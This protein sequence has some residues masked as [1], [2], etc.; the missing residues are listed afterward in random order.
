MKD[1]FSSESDKYAKFRPLYPEDMFTFIYSKVESKGSVWD[2]GTGSGQVAKKLAEEFEKVFGTDISESQLKNAFQAEN[3]HYS[4]QPAEEVDFP[5]D[6]FDLVVV[7]QAIH[8]FDFNR[9][10]AEVNRT[11]KSRGILAVVGYGMIQISE[12]IDKIIE[13]LYLNILKGY[14]DKERKYI[15][16]NYE[17]LP[18]PFDKIETPKFDSKMKWD[19]SHLIGYLKTWSAVK[20]FE[21][22]TG[23]NPVD[24]IVDQLKDVWKPEE[25]KLVSF[26]ILLRVARIQ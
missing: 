26:P 3:I 4:V 2:C 19:L 14:W 18:F 11:V 15:D 25:V 16:D 12:E 22:S 8:W 13:E 24:K 9:F 23:F 5:D 1:N 21:N 6:Y 10:Y 17:T 7:A 20:H